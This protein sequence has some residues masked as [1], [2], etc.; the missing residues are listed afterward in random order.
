MVETQVQTFAVVANQEEQY[1]IWPDARDIPDGWVAVGP[2]GPKEECLD[3]IEHVWTD[4]RPR[5]LRV[6]TRGEE[7]SSEEPVEASEDLRTL[8][9]NVLAR[10][11]DRVDAYA[12]G[13]SELFGW[14]LARV[15]EADESGS[16]VPDAA[17]AELNR[18]LPDLY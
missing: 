1:S 16:V 6:Q 15:L 9:R 8:V 18:Q 10:Y 17:R 7:A 4:M 5:S 13:R 14:F 2:T 3:Y 11:D 12:E